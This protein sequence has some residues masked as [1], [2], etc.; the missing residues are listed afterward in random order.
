MIRIVSSVIVFRDCV[1]YKQDRSPA[2][3]ADRVPAFRVL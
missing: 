1:D 3:S 2:G